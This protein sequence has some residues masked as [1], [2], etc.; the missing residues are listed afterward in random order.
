MKLRVYTPTDVV[1]ECEAVHVTVEDPSG[2]LGIRPGH[3]P[4]V[5]PL[6]RGI[7][8]AREAGGRERYVAVNGGAMIVNRDRIEVVSRQAVASRDLARLEDT[9]LAQFERETEKDRADHVAFEKMRIDF[10]RR[11]LQFEKAGETL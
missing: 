9:V 5:T 10:M 3:A 11:L 1:L 7:L 8:I 6:V 4:L 2:S